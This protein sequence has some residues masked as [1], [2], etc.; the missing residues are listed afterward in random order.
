[1]GTREYLLEKAK[2]QG[3]EQGKLEERT[4]AEAEK[5]AEKRAMALEFKKMGIPVADIAKGT[6]LSVEEI[7]NLV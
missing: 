3:L 1:M 5:L 2:K 6:G 7:N 4:K